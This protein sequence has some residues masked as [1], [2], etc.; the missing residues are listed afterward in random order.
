MSEEG[1]SNLLHEERTFPP[2][3]EFAAAANGRSE[4]YDQ[5]SADREAFWADQARKYVSWE[6]DFDQVLDWSD[7]P[8]AKWF[9]DGTLNAAYNAVDR[10]VEAGLVLERLEDALGAEALLHPDADP[11]P[12]SSGEDG[13]SGAAQG[14]GG[15]VL[16][17]HPEDGRA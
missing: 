2:S 7:A 10:H 11:C 14:L 12:A 4:L 17:E 16:G 13:R 1:L 5:A 6:N 3:E 8:V 15:L 9:A